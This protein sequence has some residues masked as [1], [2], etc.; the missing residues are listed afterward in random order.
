M[1]TPKRIKTG[2]HKTGDW[3]DHISPEQIERLLGFAPN[4]L[5]DCDKK[6]TLIWEFEI[7]GRAAA[8]WDYKGKRWSIYD[9]GGVMPNLLERL[10]IGR[11]QRLDKLC[12]ICPA[13]TFTWSSFSPDRLAHQAT[14][15]LQDRVEKLYHAAAAINS[16]TASRI[17]Q[18]D[19]I[20]ELIQRHIKY[21]VM[22]WNAQSRVASAMITGP[23]NFPTQQQEKRRES[24]RRRYDDMMAHYTGCTKRLERWAYPLGKQGD[25]VRSHDPNA[26]EKLRARLDGLKRRHGQMKTANALARQCK[27]DNAKLKDELAKIGFSDEAIANILRPNSDGTAFQGFYLTNNLAKIRAAEDRIA[28]LERSLARGTTEQRIGEFLLIVE[29]PEAHRIRL[30]FSGKP[31]KPVIAELKRRGFRWAPSHS[32][33]QRHLN[34]NGRFAAKQI[35]AFINKGE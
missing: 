2:T 9:P 25:M 16:D 22:F 7:D 26:L 19:F 17:I 14:I 10:T 5:L 20:D 28:F 23:A 1:I 8:I 33:W 31:E 27:G 4:G 13:S 3:P 18:Q 12:P 15:A 6:I 35:V 29:D 34:D 11:Q 21:T 32:A 24:E 30:I